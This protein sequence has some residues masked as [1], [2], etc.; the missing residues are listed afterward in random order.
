[1]TATDKLSKVNK[2][3]LVLKIKSLPNG[4]D[5]ARTIK[6]QYERIPMVILTPFSH[7]ITKRIANEDLSSFDYIFCWLG[8]T[9]L[10]V[11]IIK[12]IEDKMNLEH[13][14]SE[15]GVQIILLVEDGI[16]FYSSIP[17]SYTHLDVYKRQ[18]Q[19]SLGKLA[20]Q[21]DLIAGFRFQI[22]ITVQHEPT[23]T[24]LLYT[25]CR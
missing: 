25:S 3:P 1:M 9:D 14:V 24:C 15:V 8:N 23:H 17:V 20:G 6:G 10:L 11:S 19:P 16:R 5:V 4:F 13:D 12:L 22:R 21:R 18:V 2:E 7:G